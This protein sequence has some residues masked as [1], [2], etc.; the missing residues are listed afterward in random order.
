MKKHILL[1]SL[2]LAANLSHAAVNGLS[3]HSRANCVNNE[4][5]SWDW[6]KPR[7]FQTVSEH[8]RSDNGGNPW[9][10]QHTI[11]TK[12][13]VGRRSAAVHYGESVS[14]WMV[15]GIHKII[16]DTTKKTKT[17]YTKAYDCNIYDGWWNW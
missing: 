16:D 8:W 4:S 10:R 15:T 1:M 6:T 2:L 12:S 3:I 5:I 13:E 11:E 14:G 9:V 17:Y 7:H